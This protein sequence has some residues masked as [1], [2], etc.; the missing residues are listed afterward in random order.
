MPT[1]A[2][3]IAPPRL[4]LLALVLRA[5]A[6]LIRRRLKRPAPAAAATSSGDGDA[7]R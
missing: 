1:V 6:P 5:H 3:G 7:A 4:P 2:R